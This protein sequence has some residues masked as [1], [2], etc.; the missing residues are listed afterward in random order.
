MSTIRAVYENGVFRPMEPIDLPEKSVVELNPD[1][2][3]MN[4][5]ARRSMVF[6]KFY[7]ADII[8][9]I[10]T[11]PSGTTSISRDSSLS[12]YGQ[13][14]RTLGRGRPMARRGIPRLRANQG[15]SHAGRD[16]KLHSC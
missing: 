15:Q 1:R 16:D 6:M 3:R 7:P 11:W 9:A 10:T 13:V 5:R 14:D 2:C 12:R 4:S 8:V